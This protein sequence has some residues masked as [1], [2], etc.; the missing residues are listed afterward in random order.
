MKFMNL[1]P[2]RPQ[3]LRCLKTAVA[4]VLIHCP[5]AVDL[6]EGQSHVPIGANISIRDFEPLPGA[7][8]DDSQEPW[9]E[10]KLGESTY[11]T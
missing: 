9:G 3:P 4:Q 11:S 7:S 10:G 8:D 5:P 1:L 6:F 2:T